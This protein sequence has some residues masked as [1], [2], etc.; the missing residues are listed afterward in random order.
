MTITYKTFKHFIRKSVELEKLQLQSQ[1][2]LLE[3]KVR[4]KEEK[5]RLQ[6]EEHQKQDAVRIQMMEEIKSVTKYCPEKW[7]CVEF[8]WQLPQEE[9][10]KLTTKNRARHEENACANSVPAETGTM[11]S[12][13]ETNE[14]A[15]QRDKWV[16]SINQ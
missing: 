12:E 10:E 7:E 2:L 13:I 9:E 3:D 16:K 1:C 15:A 11:A 14:K 8:P 4:E 6:E 5:L